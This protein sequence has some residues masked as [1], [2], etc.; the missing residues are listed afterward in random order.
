VE[1][2]AVFAIVGQFNGGLKM[3]KLIAITAA[4]TFVC[5]PA[6]AQMSGAPAAAQT[7]PS[8]SGGMNSPNKGGAKKSKSMK[9]SNAAKK[10]MGAKDDMTK[11]SMSK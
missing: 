1:L 8:N 4:L 9:K 6:L 5:G 11:N 3:K 7:D 2:H 10:N